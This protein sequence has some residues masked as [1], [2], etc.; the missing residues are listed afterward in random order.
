LGADTT[1]WTLIGEAASGAAAAREAFARRYGPVVR[2]Y[3]AARWGGRLDAHELDDAVQEVFVECFRAGGVL[4][5]VDPAR[6][7]RAFFYGMVRNVA[8]RIEERRGRE[9]ARQAAGASALRE[10]AADDDARLS[11]VFDRAWAREVMREAAAVQA[12]RAA[13][14]AGARRRVELLRLRFSDGLA[15]REIAARWSEDAAV[16]HREYAKARREFKAALVEVM[17]F[18]YPGAPGAAERECGELLGMLG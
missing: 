7:F 3:L 11:Q 2:A 5:R 6:G 14:D 4:E 10:A 16:V 15:I 17:G 13:G 12:R 1:C 8:L 18:Y 9:R